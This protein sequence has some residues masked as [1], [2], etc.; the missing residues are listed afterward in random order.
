[1]EKTTSRPD[2]AKAT[3]EAAMLDEWLADFER[4]L[5][6]QSGE[7]LANLLAEECHWRDMFAFTWNIS[8]REGRQAIVKQMLENQ[9]RLQAQSFAIAK[10]SIPP[11]RV[12]RV[13]VEV[14]EGIFEL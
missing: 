8:P 1:M 4:A 5:A 12:K 11:R 2:H 7:Q 10:D 6:T 3:A 14:V 13:G 9:T